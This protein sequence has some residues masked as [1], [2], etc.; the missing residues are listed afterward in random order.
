MDYPMLETLDVKPLEKR[1]LASM[2]A[3]RRPGSLGR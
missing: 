2:Q 3:F 1:Q